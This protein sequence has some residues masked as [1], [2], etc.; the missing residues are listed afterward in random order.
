[1]ATIS[2]LKKKE[3]YIDLRKYASFA[4]IKNGLT[5]KLTNI[6]TKRGGSQVTI[7]I[8]E[9]KVT[10]KQIR[11]IED[12]LLDYGLYLKELRAIGPPAL[13]N[14]EEIEA[15]VFEE[16]PDYEDT[17]LIRKS[18]RSGQ[19]ILADG[20]VVILGDINPGAEIVAG[21]N[22]L[23]MGCLRGVAH[24]GVFGD[25]EAIIAAYRLIPTQI[26]IASH[27]TRPPDGE[28]IVVKTPEL[29]RIRAGKVII[30]KLKI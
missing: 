28:T 9:K 23:V 7:D 22:I 18:L 26:R 15:T 3:L 25:E 14:E 16:M 6:S 10:T 4:D 5:E 21:G 27:I 13:A 17:I 1:M 8:G 19:K 12:I 24:A 29:A 20:N 2:A 30:E 11:E